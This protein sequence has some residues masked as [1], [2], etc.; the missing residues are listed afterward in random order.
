M[1][2]VLKDYPIT[3]SEI[4][5]EASY[6]QINAMSRREL[7]QALGLSA[8]ALSAVSRTA[9]AENTSPSI[10][11]ITRD[12]RFA[13]TEELTTW[14]DASSYNNFYEFGLDKDEPKVQ[15]AN[16]KP[17]P[18]K[19]EIS[20]LCERPG[21]VDLDV[22][23]QG[24]ALEER[25]YRHRCVEAWSMVL[26]WVGVPLSAVLQ[27]FKPL[28]S[29]KF[30]AFSTLHDAKRMPGQRM[31]TLDWPYREGL[32]L[33]EAMH[34]LTLLVTG[35]YGRALPNQNGAPLRLIVPWKYGFK[36][37]KSIV[38]IEFSDRQPYTS[39]NDSAP[40]EYGFYANVN[41]AV[42]HPRW[43]QATERKLTGSGFSLFR[44]KRVKTLPFNG[45]AASVAEL[46]KGMDLTR[47][48]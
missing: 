40:D 14:E 33:D 30:V 17:L 44:S 12:P 6:Q 45:Y 9:S 32:R 5:P 35:M 42:D 38:K 34:P 16:F 25:V 13:S 10:A 36:G 31:R 18:W 8:M 3:A 26:P 37:I 11:G 46:Y 19:V 48:F 43:S 39:W 41:P 27:K 1:A 29:A 20:G 7:L 4:M 47:Y 21:V 24:L 28:S 23:L 2:S 15:A 22:L